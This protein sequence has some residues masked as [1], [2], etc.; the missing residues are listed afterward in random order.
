MTP[1]WWWWS[2]GCLLGPT[3][4]EG[5]EA[6]YDAVW[7]DMDRHYGLFEVKPDVDWDALGQDCR[8]LLPSDDAD[9]EALYAA[10]IC[11]LGPLRDDHV[12][13]LRPGADGG[14]WSA[15]RLEELER[16]DFTEAVS[17]S[18]MSELHDED[19][20]LR[21]GWVD[22][23][24][25]GGHAIGYLHVRTLDVA[26]AVDAVDG[27]MA[28]MADADGLIVDLRG[29]GGGFHSVLEPIAGY[30]AD[31]DLVY[32][33]I[34]RRDG[35]GYG[36]WLTYDLEAGEEPYLAPVALVTHAFTV[37][38][39]ENLTL[40]MR[41]LDQ[42]VHVGSATAGA[43]S[44][45]IWRDAPNGW[46]Y[47]VSVEDVRDVDGESHESVGLI[48]DV[49]AEST[50]EETRAGIDRAMEAAAASLLERVAD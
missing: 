9:A 36:A 17:A 6:T 21:W 45:A 48:P 37:S 28:A 47:A 33:R 25:V 11:L 14:L 38:G 4:P 5:A 12:R 20:T 8:A 39:A 41:E 34:R 35:E 10:L 44:S 46:L 43:F 24:R 15:G 29:N 2:A 18:W 40:A 1:V 30:F 22:P 50:L 42:V 26:H 32:S 13:L 49:Q 27:A 7:A 31:H 3:A 19:P 23:E 16:T